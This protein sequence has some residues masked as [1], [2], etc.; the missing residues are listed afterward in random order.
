MWSPGFDGYTKHANNKYFR[1]LESNAFKSRAPVSDIRIILYARSMPI[2]KPVRPA[3]RKLLRDVVFDRLRE[4]IVNGD[5]HPGE[6]IIEADVEQ[7]AGASRTPVREA[8]DRL[9]AVGL[10][11]IA[12]QRGTTVAALDPDRSAQAFS[13]LGDLVAGALRGVAAAFDERERAVLQR[14]FTAVAGP[15]DLLVPGGAFDCVVAVVGN[16]RL[17]QVYDEIAP[18]V[19]RAWRAGVDVPSIDGLDTTTIGDAIVVG[20]GVAAETAIRTWFGAVDP[21]VPA[22]RSEEAV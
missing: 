11:V 14:A 4:A 13:L 9:A 18:H 21:F 10:V 2:P 19:L 22:T 17:R 8:L 16:S 15:I 7:W 12:P 6:D 1:L 3:Q 5:L 20:D